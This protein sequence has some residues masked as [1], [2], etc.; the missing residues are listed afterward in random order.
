MPLITIQNSI[1]QIL[2]PHFCVIRNL[3]Q[4]ETLVDCPFDVSQLRGEFVGLTHTFEHARRLIPRP[5]YPEDATRRERFH[6]RFGWDDV[7]MSD[8]TLVQQVP[9][10]GF[11]DDPRS[12]GSHRDRSIATDNE[13]FRE[14]YTIFWLCPDDPAVITDTLIEHVQQIRD[15]E[16]HPPSLRSLLEKHHALGPYSQPCS[17]ID[18]YLLLYVGQN[19]FNRMCLWSRDISKAT[20]ETFITQV[21]R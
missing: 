19:Y 14:S 20:R 2:L 16:T 13:L 17:T 21:S 7:Q 1:G 18:G 3:D 6:A 10:F 8:G 11:D 9:T 4:P 15:C 12:V 5:E